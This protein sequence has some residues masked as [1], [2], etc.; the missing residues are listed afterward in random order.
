MKIGLIT[1]IH[2]QVEVLA[3]ALEALRGHD[4]EMIVLIGD[5]V[6]AGE[7]L[8]ETCKLL[9]NHNVVG[10]WGNHDYLLCSESR[11]KCHEKD[12]K[13]TAI[14]MSSLRPRFEVDQCLFQHVDPGLTQMI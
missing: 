11:S 5:V 13:A 1:D 12:A 7:R 4:V 10:V 6:A 2:E 3:I 8:D 9:L 14:F